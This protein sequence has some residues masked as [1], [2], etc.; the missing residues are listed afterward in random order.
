MRCPTVGQLPPPPPGKRG[1]P[2]TEGSAAIEERARAAWPRVSVIV[3][4]FQQGPF[5]EETIRS[6]LLQGYPDLE[7][8]INDG[9]STDETVPILRK[10]DRW[11]ASWVSEK[12]GGQSAA[13]NAGWRRATGALLSWLNSDDLVME[14]WLA[15]AVP[16][17]VADPGL[18]CT[19]GQV[20]V[21]DVDSR[22]L[23]IYPD[24][25]PSI[26][27]V[28]VDWKM[29]FAHMGYLMRRECL[30]RVGYLSESVHFCM[31]VDYCLRLLL[32]G[33]R[34]AAVP[35]DNGRFR[36]H[37]QGKTRNHHKVLLADMIKIT[38][39][40]CASA[41]P[42]MS[43]IVQRARQRMYWNAA[44]SSY[45]NRDHVEARRSAARHLRDAGWRAAP[46][47]AG[48]VALSLLGERGH[49][50]LDAWRK[51]KGSP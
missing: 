20:K 31:D 43:D 38:N 10:Y 8:I 6:V 51:L 46:R 49:D 44:H 26:E 7:L 19:Y 29:P 34:F 2:W 22:P 40:F 41:P 27:T 47:V 42:E 28:V 32:K 16:P 5:I 36:L 30:E 39:D 48:M 50:V 17:M 15:R 13:V 3:P 25:V 23:F 4:S 12:D 37:E 1:W 9:G 45:Y 21:M 18:D 14:G 33:C 11:I 24:V 35:G